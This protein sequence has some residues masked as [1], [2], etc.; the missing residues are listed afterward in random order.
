MWHL[1]RQAA[2]YHWP[3]VI[4]VTQPVLKETEGTDPDQGWSAGFLLGGQC[5]LAA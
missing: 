5:P 1:C 2:N 4:R 3:D